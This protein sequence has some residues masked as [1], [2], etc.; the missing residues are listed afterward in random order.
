MLDSR[1]RSLGG[2][3][4][5]HRVERVGPGGRAKAMLAG[6]EDA[7]VLGA[8]PG[9]CEVI[10]DVAPFMTSSIRGGFQK[11]EAAYHCTRR[12]RSRP[13]PGKAPCE[14]GAALPYTGLASVF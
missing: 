1:H 4:R 8:I 6:A 11:P 3:A 10:G 9:R 12:S 2:L 7:A 13:A 14:V 5:V